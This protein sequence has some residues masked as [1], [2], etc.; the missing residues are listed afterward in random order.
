MTK[1]ALVVG[2][3]GLRG[4]YGA[5]VMATLARELGPNY[6]D[7]VYG[8]SVGV[9]AATFF[10]ANQPGVIERT[11]RNLVHGKQLVNFANPLIGRQILD[12]EYLVG[13]FQDNRSLLDVEAVMKSRTKL[14]YT[15][16]KYPTGKPAY[17]QPTRKNIFDAMRASSAI[18][19]VHS[20]IEVNGSTFVDGGLTS[21]LPVIKALEDGNE[22]II[23]VYSKPPGFTSGPPSRLKRSILNLLLPPGIARLLKEHHWQEEELDRILETNKKLKILRPT[24]ELPLNSRLDTNKKR[25]NASIDRGIK[26]A[27]DFLE[28]YERVE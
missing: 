22:E 23:V 15:V 5:G 17:I 6:F 1:K 16:T 8:S 13:L 26:D 20:P 11:W 24:T 3:G 10:L 7:A 9:Y 21:N 2:G 19:L 28:K 18:P 25:I 27:K 14:V 4:A 12:L